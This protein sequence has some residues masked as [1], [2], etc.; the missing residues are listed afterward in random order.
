MRGAN[1]AQSRS[2]KTIT[3][4]KAPSGFSLINRHSPREIACRRTETFPTVD[5]GKGRLISRIVRHLHDCPSRIISAGTSLVSPS[6]ALH[7]SL[8]SLLSQEL[9][10]M[11]H[12]S[13]RSFVGSILI[14][15][16]EVVKGLLL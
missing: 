15:A 6:H 13:V 14:R 12:E 5:H 7:P 9:Y 3:P 1:R 4:P 16:I 11:A 10:Y 2:P 8:A